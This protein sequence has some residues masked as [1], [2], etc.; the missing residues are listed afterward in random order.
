VD[1]IKMDIRE[2]GWDGLDWI[3]VA[4]WRALVN[5]NNEPSGSIK[6]SELY[7]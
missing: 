7:E 4:Q 5:M 3:D 2:I 1:N 6:C